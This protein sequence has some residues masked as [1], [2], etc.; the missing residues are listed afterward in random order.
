MLQSTR[1]TPPSARARLNMMKT[2]K[3][4]GSTVMDPDA[5]RVIGILLN[6]LVYRIS[7]STIGMY[8]VPFNAIA[9]VI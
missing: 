1:L 4:G 9:Q 6:L 5:T 7:R 8:L 3:T 2:V